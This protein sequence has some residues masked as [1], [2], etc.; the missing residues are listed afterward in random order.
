MRLQ[1][2]M[3]HFD[4]KYKN[5]FAWHLQIILKRTQLMFKKQRQPAAD[6]A[7]RQLTDFTSENDEVSRREKGMSMN[8]LKTFM[9]DTTCERQC[10]A[11]N[12]IIADECKIRLQLFGSI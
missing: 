3:R 8:K 5:F 4:S 1:P 6:G 2:L 11:S 7:I 12:L 9:G 10:C